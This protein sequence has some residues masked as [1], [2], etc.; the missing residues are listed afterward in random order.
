M[1]RPKIFKHRWW[2][3]WRRSYRGL[4]PIRWETPDLTKDAFEIDGF[5]SPKDGGGGKFSI[6]SKSR[7]ESKLVV[8]EGFYAEIVAE[9]VVRAEWFGVEK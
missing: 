1:S 3:F 7:E 9:E 8:P 2:R 6:V 4:N 5:F